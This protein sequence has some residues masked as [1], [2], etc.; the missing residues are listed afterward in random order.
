[1]SDFIKNRKVLLFTI[2]LLLINVILKII[3]IDSNDIAKDEPFSIYVAQMSLSELVNYLKGGNNPPLYEIFL[4]FWIKFFGTDALSVRLPSLIFSSLTAVVI[5]RAGKSAFSFSTGA[6]ASLIFTFSSMHTY[7]AHEARAYALFMLLTALSILFLINYVKQNKIKDISLLALVNILL[8][9]THYFGFFVLL[10]Q[11]IV[12]IIH[13]RNKTNL[14]RT[15]LHAILVFLA[16][17]PMLKLFVRQFYYSVGRG[18]WVEPP[19][20]NQFYGFLNIFLNNKYVSILYVFLFIIVCADIYLINRTLKWP[21]LKKNTK[22][23]HYIFAGFFIPYSIMFL[24]SFKAPMFIERYVL[25]TSVYFYL[26]LS[27]IITCHTASKNLKI[28]VFALFLAGMIYTYNMKPDNNRNISEAVGYVKEQKQEDALV[29]VCPHYDYY[30]F[31]YYYNPNI[32]KNYNETIRLLEHDNV[33]LIA[34]VKDLAVVLNFKNPQKII[35]FQSVWQNVDPDNLIFKNLEKNFKIQEK[36][37][38]IE[39]Y[40]V[41]VF[42]N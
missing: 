13:K 25:F 28:I 1:M 42:G 37:N 34:S 31:S 20:I 27:A 6:L 41:T 2:L 33:F 39:I 14:L 22:M 17:L 10:N 40:S 4:H 38:F 3:Y 30:A 5:F 8:I 32:F 36:R 16:F 12:L 29:L 35:Y 19:T 15:G 21:L 18:T 9:Y 23:L 24:A 26:F 7:F 11:L